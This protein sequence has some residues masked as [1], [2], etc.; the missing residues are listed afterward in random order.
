[1]KRINKVYLVYDVP[2]GQEAIGSPNFWGQSNYRLVYQTQKH[3]TT[4]KLAQENINNS[5]GSMYRNFRI[6][7]LEF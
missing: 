5:A 2:V 4:R 6:E 7:E 3:I 1:M